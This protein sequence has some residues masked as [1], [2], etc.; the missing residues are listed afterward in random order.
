MDAPEATPIGL[1]AADVALV[2]AKGAG[3]V[4]SPR[5][6]TLCGDTAAVPMYL[7]AGVPVA[8]GTDWVLSGSM[9]L[10]RELRCADALNATAFGKTLSDETLW[11]MGTAYAADVTQ[12]AKKMGRLSDGKVA[13]LVI[14]R[15]QERTP[16]RT[17]L[18]AEPADV[19]LVFRGGKS[20]MAIRRW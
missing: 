7:R 16:Y 11:G 4:W 18:E 2:A 3:L 15:R 13:D 14:H 5:S 10:L 9:N 17:V 6:S 8:L 1:E 12:T 20:S 19:A